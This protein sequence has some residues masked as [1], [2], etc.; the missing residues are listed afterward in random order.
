MIRPFVSLVQGN[1][2]FYFCDLLGINDC[3][4]LF[5]LNNTSNLQ[6]CLVWPSNEVSLC[7]IV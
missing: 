7:K 6:T 3:Y 2:I 1:T 5:N 4:I